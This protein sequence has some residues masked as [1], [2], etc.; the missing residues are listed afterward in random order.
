MSNL[1]DIAKSMDASSKG[2]LKGRLEDFI[3]DAAILNAVLMIDD[4]LFDEPELGAMVEM[5]VYKHISS[6]F[7]GSTA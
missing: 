4:V 5:T 1:F 2:A 6:F 3:A 7:Q